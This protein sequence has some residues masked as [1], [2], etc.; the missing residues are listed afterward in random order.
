MEV[1]GNVLLVGATSE[2]GNAILKQI[3]HHESNTLYLIGNSPDSNQIYE[4]WTGE[5]VHFRCDFTNQASLIEGVN[6]IDKLPSLAFAIVASGHLPLENLDTKSESILPTFQINSIGVTMLA[7]AIMR[8]FQSQNRGML[9]LISSVAAVRPRVRNFSYG[10]SKAASDF[11][12]RG[13]A[14]KYNS[15]NVKVKVLRPGFVHTKMTEGFIPAPFAVTAEKVAKDAIQRIH[16]KRVVIYSPPILRYVME[17]LKFLPDW[18][19]RRL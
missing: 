13:M 6:F 16:L 9:L 12:A 14:S 1:R 8:K 18:I 15:K 17:V 19:F 7:A 2:I 5:V 11:F 4:N 3:F 10:A